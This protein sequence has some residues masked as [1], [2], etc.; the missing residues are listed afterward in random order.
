VVCCFAVYV[1]MFACTRSYNKIVQQSTIINAKSCESNKREY[2]STQYTD[3]VTNTTLSLSFFSC[4]P[5]TSPY[6]IRTVRD[7]S[8]YRT[9]AYMRTETAKQQTTKIKKIKILDNRNVT[10]CKIKKIKI[11]KYFIFCRSNL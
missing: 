6:S 3:I 10:M 9:C 2:H 5:H 7:F 1:R 11:S 8:F 4:R